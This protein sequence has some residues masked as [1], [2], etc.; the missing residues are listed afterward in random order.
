MLFAQRATMGFERL[1]VE[2]FCLGIA[3]LRFENN[4]QIVHVG[5]RTGVHDKQL[6]SKAPL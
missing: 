6:R 2:C 5:K 3:A 4:R 1:K